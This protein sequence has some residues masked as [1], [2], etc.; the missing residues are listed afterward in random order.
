MSLLVRAG[1]N[2]DPVTGRFPADLGVNSNWDEGV[3]RRWWREVLTPPGRLEG[4]CGGWASI[5][6]EP[7]T[8]QCG[9]CPE[10]PWVC[11]W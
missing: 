9:K 2:T 4:K 8:A 11:Y 3:V 10:K 5:F 6:S 7:I 1:P